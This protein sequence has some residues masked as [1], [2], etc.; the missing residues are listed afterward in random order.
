M[1]HDLDQDVNGIFVNLA[2]INNILLYVLSLMDGSV[3]ATTGWT[4]R[5]CK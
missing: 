4:H 1:Q 5:N 3:A 2:V